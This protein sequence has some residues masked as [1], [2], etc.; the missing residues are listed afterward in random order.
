M[1]ENPAFRSEVF[2]QGFINDRDN[3]VRPRVA[4]ASQG[5]LLPF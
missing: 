2:P 1:R 4:P 5:F 3:A